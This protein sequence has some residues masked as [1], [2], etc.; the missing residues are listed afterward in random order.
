[1]K[2]LIKRILAGL[3][4]LAVILPCLRMIPTAFAEEGEE[5]A[6]TNEWQIVSGSEADAATKYVY[7]A[8]SNSIM[9]IR[10]Y[11]EPTEKEDEFIIHMKAES[12]CTHDWAELFPASGMLV[13]N[14]NSTDAVVY[15]GSFT[16]ND[17]LAAITALLKGLGIKVNGHQSCV[18]ASPAAENYPPTGADYTTQKGNDI[19]IRY[20]HLLYD[21]QDPNNY[22]T[23]DLGEDRMVWSLSQNSGSSFTIYY[24]APNSSKIVKLSN[25]TWD[26]L[27]VKK[28]Y[29]NPGTITVPHEAYDN[30]VEANKMN[31]EQTMRR[32]TPDSVTDVLSDGI[33]FCGFEYCSIGTPGTQTDPV[34]GRTV[35]YW[36]DMD[37]EATVNPD[38]PALTYEDIE[39]SDDW[40]EIGGYELTY[41]VRL[42]TEEAG[43]HS[44]ANAMTATSGVTVYGTS[45]SADIHYYEGQTDP[46]GTLPTAAYDNPEVR[47]TLYDLC[48]RK[49]NENGAALAGAQFTLYESDGMTVAKDSA[50]NPYT[51]TTDATGIV[52]LYGIPNGNYVLKEV[53]PA[54][55]DGDVL[56][57]PIELCYTADHTLYVRDVAPHDTNMRFAG[58]DVDGTWEIE[59]H[60]FDR[61][62][63]PQTVVLDYGIPVVIRAAEYCAQTDDLSVTLC[64]IAAAGAGSTDATRTLDKSYDNPSAVYPH[65]TVKIEDGKLVYTPTDMKM[66]EKDVINVAYRYNLRGN[67]IYL[68]ST[69][70]VVPATMIY[71]EDYAQEGFITYQNTANNVWQTANGASGGNTQAEDRPGALEVSA[72]LDANNVY[73]Y[74]DVNLACT[75]YSL[76]QSHFVTV[77][78]G[79]YAANGS[80]WPTAAFTFTGTAFDIISMTDSQTGF[81]AVYVY[82]GEQATGTP[83]KQWVVDTYFGYSRQQNGYMRHEW[84][85]S[86]NKWHVVN[87]VVEQPGDDATTLPSNPESIDTG[88][89]YV[90][91]EINYEWVPTG[92]SASL[93]QIPVVKSPILPYGTY[94]V[95][96]TPMFGSYFDHS[97][98]GSYSFYLDAVRVYAP[99]Q[100]YE[101]YNTQY[102]ELDSEGWPQYIELRNNLIEAAALDEETGENVIN[103]VVFIDSVASG[104]GVSDYASYGPNNEVYLT[105][106]QSVSF[107]LQCENNGESVDQVHLG[108]K[109]ITGGTGSL[110]VSTLTDDLTIAGASDMFYNI[111][112]KLTW[113]G[114]ISSVITVTNNSGNDAVISLTQLKVTYKSEE[115]NTVCMIVS[116]PSLDTVVAAAQMQYLNSISACYHVYDYTVAADP[117]ADSPGVLTCCCRD[118]GAAMEIEIPALNDKDYSCISVDSAA[119]TAGSMTYTWKET[120]Y[121]VISVTLPIDPVRPDPVIDAPTPVTEL[122]IRS[123]YLRL[124]DNINMVYA[125]DVPDGFEGPYMVFT[126][127]GASY[128][129]TDYTTDA[130]GRYCFEFTGIT[131][132]HMGDSIRAV[133]HAQSADGEFTDTVDGYSIR[134]YCENQLAYHADNA[135]LVTLL[136][137]LLTYGAAAQTYTGYRADELVTEGL[138]LMPGACTVPTATHG[139]LLLGE[140]DSPEDWRSAAL[141]LGSD[142]AMRFSFRAESVE[143]LTV[144]VKGNG[145]VQTFGEE[146]FK[147]D[148]FGEDTWYV[149]YTGIQATEFNDWVS[150]RFYRGSVQVGR[151]IYYSVNAY[152]S[153]ARNIENPKLVQLTQALYRYGVSAEQYAEANRR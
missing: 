37:N 71:Y 2:R 18:V 64:G 137:D 22:L 47:G 44:C 5:A 43:F 48:F 66:T 152:L 56:E 6:P 29:H 49:V 128:T 38:R 100:D 139:L 81:A 145:R 73:G 97:K 17:T 1:M 125:V 104:N 90:T 74:D 69:V 30:L 112:E 68:Y 151:T 42:K 12:V 119:E 94:T 61:S 101:G 34:T 106:G 107:S 148:P 8:E 65:G 88:A 40:F 52:G 122:K 99:A 53:P 14:N 110:N 76:G 123:A 25:I 109:K 84:T 67:D 46:G 117:T 10:K 86:G 32:A 45:T 70:T 120:A 80:K 85:Y 93:Y 20:F 57:W 11:I 27:G 3:L 142:W 26:G 98:A 135:E 15:E 91:Y 105:N 58:N 96:I 59:N 28:D 95:Q 138:T 72:E 19:Y 51:V 140:K 50:N 147:H 102:Y 77:A 118:C 103:G 63:T 83:Y 78:D 136:S 143:G 141:I 146:D 144:R 149:D 54:F 126:M 36:E 21:E 116:K 9:R 13:C 24:C 75:T 111:S 60:S 150:A 124:S 87:T 133:V 129:V 134:K 89:A 55:Y 127:N 23:V 4:C 31:A 79:D 153:S 62:L 121:G 33:E 39:G 115:N 41:R 35:I 7:D 92:E 131:P 130:P 82:Q 16:P 113:N 132:Q 114:N 108:I